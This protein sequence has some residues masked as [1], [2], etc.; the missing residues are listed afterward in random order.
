MESPKLYFAVVNGLMMMIAFYVAVWV[1]NYD[2]A[3][4]YTV[5][6]D[7]WRVSVS[8]VCACIIACAQPE[9]I[10]APALSSAL[11]STIFQFFSF[12]PGVLSVVLFVYIFNCACIIKVSEQVIRTLHFIE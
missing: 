4:D 12:F 5:D 11:L 3:A 10:Y 8:C 7:L 1:T 9:N 6:S 2:I